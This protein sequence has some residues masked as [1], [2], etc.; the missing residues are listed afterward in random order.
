MVDSSR[1]DEKI[2]R[3]HVNADPS[4]PWVIYVQF[5]LDISMMR[6]S[7]KIT[8]NI[9]ESTSV[10]DETDFLVLMQ[11]S[12]HPYQV[13]PHTPISGNILVKKHLHLLLSECLSCEID[14]VAILVRSGSGHLINARLPCTG[15]ING[16]IP[17][18]HF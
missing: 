5:S 4:I 13:N 17:V 6:F 18:E 3:S 11:V 14:K 2:A 7:C 15:W 9:E 12:G 10:E 1:K 8:A 16:N